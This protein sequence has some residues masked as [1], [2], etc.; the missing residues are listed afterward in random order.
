MAP[1]LDSLTKE[2]YKSGFKPKSSEARAWFMGR[3]QGF[4]GITASKLMQEQSRMTPKAMIGGMFFFYYDAKL[5]DTLPYW[6]KFP[7]IV[8]VDFYSDSFH[9]I[10]FHYLD[11]WAR[12][13]LL[14]KLTQFTSN[15]SLNADAKLKVSYN[16]LKSAKKYKE[17]QPC[18]KKYLYSQLRSK[19]LTVQ[20]EEY[21][22]AIFL[23]VQQF[24]KATGPEVWENSFFQGK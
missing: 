16:Y 17:V 3:L 15:K 8:P 7:L 10:N 21:E 23:P 1:L 22:V 19:F 9:G 2:Y 6:D 24:Q 13:A 18:F 12:A 20:P 11:P 5:K 4:S 14:D